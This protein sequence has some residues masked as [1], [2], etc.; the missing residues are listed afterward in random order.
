MRFS[1]S[2]EVIIRR[3]PK[4]QYIVSFEK[5]PQTCFKIWTLFWT[6][7]IRQNV[8]KNL[9]PLYYATSA[10]CSQAIPSL[11]N[12]LS[13]C[14]RIYNH[15]F[16][17]ISMMFQSLSS[18]HILVFCLS[19][20]I[21]RNEREHSIT[22]LVLFIFQ[23]VVKAIPSE[24]AIELKWCHMLYKMKWLSAYWV[25]FSKGARNLLCIEMVA[26]WAAA[27]SNLR[28]LVRSAETQTTGCS[29]CSYP[30]AWILQDESSAVVS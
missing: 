12:V 19:V 26:L 7:R 20:K 16:Q 13:P 14:Y 8:W 9:K 11:L 5:S 2:I 6:A 29:Q 27:W 1:K 22:L 18:G 30:G 21:S 25:F 10:F 4:N 3:W 28:V 23:Y 15:Q 24:Q 17:I